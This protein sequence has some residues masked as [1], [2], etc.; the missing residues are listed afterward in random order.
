MD[1]YQLLIE[2]HSKIM[3]EISTLNQ[4]IS[5]VMLA[6]FWNYFVILGYFGLNLN[7]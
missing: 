3:P 7:C 2:I 4:Q 1:F 6:K 5:V